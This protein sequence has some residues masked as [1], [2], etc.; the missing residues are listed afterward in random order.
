MSNLEIREK[1]Q[2]R[3][4]KENLGIEEISKRVKTYLIDPLIKMKRRQ[5]TT[6]D[7]K[8]CIDKYLENMKKH[9]Q[10]VWLI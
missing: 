10:I 9:T 6:E 8:E 1:Q 5:I 7:K 4:H 3:Q 2:K